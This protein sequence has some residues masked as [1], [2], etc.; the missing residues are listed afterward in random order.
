MPFLAPHEDYP[1]DYQFG[2]RQSEELQRG[3]H[4]SNLIICTKTTSNLPCSLWPELW[5]ANKQRKL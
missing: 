4:E 2:L 3:Q 1:Q 5:K